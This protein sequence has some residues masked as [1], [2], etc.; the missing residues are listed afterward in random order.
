VTLVGRLAWPCFWR[1]A[2]GGLVQPGGAGGCLLHSLCALRGDRLASAG[3]CA[4]PQDAAVEL[5]DRDGWRAADGDGEERCGGN[6]D[7]R[8]AVLQIEGDKRIN[9]C[10]Y[11]KGEDAAGGDGARNGGEE[12]D[13]RRALAETALE[14]IAGSFQ[15]VVLRAAL[16]G[17]GEEQDRDDGRGGGVE[18][19]VEGRRRC[20][21]GVC[22]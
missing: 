21:G 17:D 16:D 1:V 22:Q 2:G 20:V 12:W 5:D 6:H 7:H 18:R 19:A 13:D 3:S 14:R 11:P 10:E 15:Q 8:L 4:R 9:V